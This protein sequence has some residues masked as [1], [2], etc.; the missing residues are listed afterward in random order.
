MTDVN[1]ELAT[2][3]MEATG[4]GQQ[5]ITVHST[6]GDGAVGAYTIIIESDA[7][8]VL[9]LT[10]AEFAAQYEASALPQG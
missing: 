7:P 10:S 6:D 1:A 3:S 5:S 4:F 9:H 2:L 8:P